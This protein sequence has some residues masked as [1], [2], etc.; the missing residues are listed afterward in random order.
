MRR[1]E[2]V[3]TVELYAHRNHTV[4]SLFNRISK[5]VYIVFSTG[6]NRENNVS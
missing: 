2:L 5:S 4:I 1:L 6:D 3:V